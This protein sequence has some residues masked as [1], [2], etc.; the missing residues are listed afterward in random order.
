MSH[1]VLKTVLQMHWHTHIL[2]HGSRNDGKTFM[3]S[4]NTAL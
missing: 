4:D 3:F 1:T 2:N